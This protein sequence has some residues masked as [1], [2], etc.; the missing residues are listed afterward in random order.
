[1]QVHDISCEAVPNFSFDSGEVTRLSRQNP[2]LNN[3]WDKLPQ[4]KEITWESPEQEKS[5]QRS[6][7]SE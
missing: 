4:R 6:T 2:T 5:S 7:I 3:T 1:M